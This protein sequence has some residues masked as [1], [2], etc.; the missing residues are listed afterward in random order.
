M[1]NSLRSIH[2]PLLYIRALF[3]YSLFV[4]NYINQ[5]Y[6]AFQNLEDSSFLQI[7]EVQENNYVFSS[8]NAYDERTLPLFQRIFNV[9][10]DE[11]SQPL[12]KARVREIFVNMATFNENGAP[13]NFESREEMEHLYLDRPPVFESFAEDKAQTSGKG[14]PG[15]CE[16]VYLQ[17]LHFFSCRAEN[18][19]QKY[20]IR[21]AEFLT[22]RLADREIQEGTWIY[23]GEE[24]IYQVERVV[25]Q[26]GAYIAILK[27]RAHPN[28]IKI[29]CRGTA[30]RR[31]AT[32]G[33]LS[34]LNDLQ[35]EIGNGGVQA[36]WPFLSE[37]LSR[38]QNLEVEIYGKSLGGAHAQR[39]AILVMLLPNCTLKELTTVGSVG[40]GEEAEEM[41]KELLEQTHEFSRLTVIRNGGEQANDGADY[42]PCMGGEHLGATV[43]SQFLDRRV[44]YIHPQANPITK[45]LS[46][47]SFFQNLN[48]F[49]KSF[50]G[51]HVRQTTLQDFSY[52]LV[53][54]DEIQDSLSIGNRL[55]NLRRVIAYKNC[56]SFTEFVHN[57]HAP[58][59]IVFKI[60]V[61]ASD[62]FLILFFTGFMTCLAVQ[63]GPVIYQ[64]TQLVLTLPTILMGEG[65]I[66]S[67]F[68]LFA[69]AFASKT[70][71]SESI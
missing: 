2:I 69:H 28:Q 33:L 48:R 35:Y 30:M 61:V 45:P 1:S 3:S 10:I 17:W 41:F 44:Y 22:S 15:L 52:Q 46:M 37:Y 26:G 6:A 67:L 54:S 5:I 12:T 23:L 59:L 63:Y 19:S 36:S 60:G 16:T 47:L 24:K 62:I 34:A 43:S 8:S 49:I 13:L 27:N 50:S 14:F 40:V 64:S 39:L 51:P 32:G 42:I 56:V 21:E 68:A 57:P 20:E 38:H 53:E 7:N 11:S 4:A 29:V 65:M 55:E 9:H 71:I 70:Q 58:D 18:D 66:L 31:T 25:A